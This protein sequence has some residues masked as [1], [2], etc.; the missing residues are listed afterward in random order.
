MARDR[1][2]ENAYMGV[3]ASYGIDLI[4]AEYMSGMWYVEADVE[5]LK[6]KEIEV[7]KMEVEMPSI[8]DCLEYL[9]K[10]VVKRNSEAW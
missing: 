6:V 9:S 8:I 3:L 1:E 10:E 4:K 5:Y 2:I 7:M